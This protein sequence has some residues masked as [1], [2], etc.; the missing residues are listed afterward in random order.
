[1]TNCVLCSAHHPG[2]PCNG[3]C[4]CWN[5]HSAP[6]PPGPVTPA[7]PHP[8]QTYFGTKLPCAVPD[9]LGSGTS[10]PTC[11]IPVE[12][13]A[14]TGRLDPFDPY[15]RSLLKVM[16]HR[17]WL[18]SDPS[19]AMWV[20]DPCIARGMDV[21]LDCKLIAAGLEGALVGE[22]P[23]AVVT[24]PAPVHLHGVVM[25]APGE[26]PSVR[27]GGC[28]YERGGGPESYY[29]VDRSVKPGT[30]RLPTEPL[31]WP[32]AT[33]PPDELDALPLEAKKQ[34]S[35]LNRDYDDG[36]I[37]FGQAVKDA[38]AI[39]APTIAR[40]SGEIAAAQAKAATPRWRIPRNPK[41][42]PWQPSVDEFDLLPDA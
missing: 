24:T 2:Q 15:S 27:C 10:A 38:Q 11:A 16:F 39:I 41:P 31:A 32:M 7:C 26:N 17:E 21:T 36:K 22:A 30:M 9:C 5:G 20:P 1:M 14:S 28:R 13:D 37:S 8:R 3:D 25:L 42:E 18:T 12:R 33:E 29:A 6:H 35:Q 40:L 23:T 19:R 34:L 4:P